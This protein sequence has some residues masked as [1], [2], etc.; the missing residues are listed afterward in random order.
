MSETPKLEPCP[1]CGGRTIQLFKP[2][3]R[4]ET[5]YNPADRLYPRVTCMHCHAD[6]P[7]ANEDYRGETAI[8]AWNRRAL[9]PGHSD[10]VTVPLE[11]TEEMLRAA[12]D[13]RYQQSKRSQ[14]VKAKFPH[15]YETWIKVGLKEDAP[16]IIREY[17]AMLS[18][19]PSTTPAPETQKD[20]PHE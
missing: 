14:N 5:P 17:K 20:I 15:G 16:A 13:A 4:P 9:Q 10:S 8:T 7:G 6:V 19:A 1:F 12:L 18:A 3:C 2:T 11:P